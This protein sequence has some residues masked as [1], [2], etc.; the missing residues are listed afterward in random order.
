M[1]LCDGCKI[2]NQCNCVTVAMRFTPHISAVSKK[3]T[4]SCNAC[5]T[6]ANVSPSSCGPHTCAC[7]CAIV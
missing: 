4:P 6:H 7:S 1:Q 3:L 2:R 5:L